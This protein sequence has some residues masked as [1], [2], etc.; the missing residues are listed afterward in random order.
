MNKIICALFV[1]SLT[2]SSFA[3]ATE[4]DP[5]TLIAKAELEK[6]FGE[7]KEGPKAKEGLMKEKGCEWSNMAGSWINIFVYSA[8]KLGL[9][10]GMLND[11]VDLTGLGDEAFTAK[12]G[13]DAEIYIRKG[14]LVLEVRTSSGAE[15]AKRAAQQALT[16]MP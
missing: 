1:F 9:K 15:V 4:P 12:R 6:I 5:C 14:Q 2:V 3:Q 8:D 11:P 7:I 16:K 13:T 10:K